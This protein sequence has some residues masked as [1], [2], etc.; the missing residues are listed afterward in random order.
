M[1]DTLALLRQCRIAGEN[2]QIRMADVKT[3]VRHLQKMRHFSRACCF[4]MQ[5][6]SKHFS[7]NSPIGSRL[8]H[9]ICP[10]YVHF[11]QTSRLFFF[12]VYL[13]LSCH[14]P[15]SSLCQFTVHLGLGC[16]VGQKRWY[17]GI[18]CQGWSVS[19]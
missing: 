19:W 3:P 12:S 8:T 6:K 2:R 7:I 14:V 15:I 4:K 16:L 18:G 9:T 11:R 1:G 13:L 5:P 10:A 17:N